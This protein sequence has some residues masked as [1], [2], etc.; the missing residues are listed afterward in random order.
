MVASSRMT[1][2][3]ILTFNFTVEFFFISERKAIL[4]AVWNL[5]F[6][7]PTLR[8]VGDTTTMK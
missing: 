4:T 1:N 7:L 6:F 5:K 3:C 2:F 8:K